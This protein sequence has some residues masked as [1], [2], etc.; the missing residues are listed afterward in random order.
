MPLG[1]NEYGN[2]Q[3]EDKDDREMFRDSFDEHNDDENENE[4]NINDDRAEFLD[5]QSAIN[6]KFRSGIENAPLQISDKI[7]SNLE[8]FV[9]YQSHTHR[10]LFI[11]TFFFMLGFGWVCRKAIFGMLRAKRSRSG[12][13]IARTDGGYESG[14]DS[15]H[16]GVEDRGCVQGFLKHGN[17]TMIGTDDQNDKNGGENM[18][19]ELSLGSGWSDKGDGDSQDWEK[20]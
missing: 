15:T 2:D 11:V 1:N 8:D 16:S 19:D 10:N 12:R 9:E 5:N 4:D 20:W 6:P 18:D 13:R 3:S 17:Y 7:E 14:V